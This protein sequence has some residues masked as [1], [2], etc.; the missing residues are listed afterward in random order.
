MKTDVKDVSYCMRKGHG[1]SV[2]RSE[3][4]KMLN[5]NGKWIRTCVSCKADAMDRRAEK[6]G[7]K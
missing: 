4:T 3:M 2:P 6:R 5:E 1:H 7:G